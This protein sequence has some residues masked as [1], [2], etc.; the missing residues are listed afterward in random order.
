MSGS[1]Q[2]AAGH[3]RGPASMHA[4]DAGQPFE[5][6]VCGVDGSR[7]ARLAVDQAI[8]LSGPNTALV[9]ICVREASGA[10]ASRQSNITVDRAD[11][12]LQAAVKAAREAGID[13]AAELLPGHDPRRVL[14]DE[15]SRADLLVVASHSASRAGG[16]ALGGTASAA[17][18]SARVPVLVARRAPPDVA[19]PER[20]LVGDDGSPDAAR[21]VE[22][23]VRIGRRHGAQVYLLSVDPS[24]HG[25]PAEIAVDAVEL[26]AALSAEPTVMRVSGHAD[27]QILQVAGEASVALVAVG[28]RG[29][30]GLRALG[31]VSER[32]AHRARC[33]VLVARPA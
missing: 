21:A 16:I 27:E 15:A 8:A 13:A 26:A 20:I 9:F 17:V 29:L 25:D 6:I 12:A 2:P 5:R 23:A 28:S 33:S 11:G 24:P 3:A 30:T 4:S 32:V 18:H 1:Y 14:L 22:L 7:S 31:S 10:G 19:F